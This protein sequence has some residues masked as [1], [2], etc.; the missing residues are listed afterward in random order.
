MAEVILYFLVVPAKNPSKAWWQAVFP[1]GHGATHFV[2]R[3]VP[4]HNYVSEWSVQDDFQ[5]S[6]PNRYVTTKRLPMVI[7]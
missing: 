3:N 1:D 5:F 2:K 7:I 6:W 4:G